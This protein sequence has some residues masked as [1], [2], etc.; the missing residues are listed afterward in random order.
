[1]ATKFAKQQ[2]RRR[3]AETGIVFP[4]S[5]SIEVER[6][7]QDEATPAAIKSIAQLIIK[8][9]GLRSTFKEVESLKVICSKT[10]AIPDSETGPCKADR[11]LLALLGELLFLENSRPVHRQLLS[12]L[13]RLPAK[14]FAAFRNIILEKVLIIA[15]DFNVRRLERSALA[16]S[17]LAQSEV[18]LPRAI[19]ADT[20]FS[21]LEYKP[22]SQ[23]LRRVCTEALAVLAAGVLDV[24]EAAENGM[25]IMQSSAEEVQD[26]VSGMYAILQRHGGYIAEEAGPKGHEAIAAAAEAMLLLLQSPHIV[27]R[28]A[29][30]SAAVLLGSACLLPAVPP[31]TLAA[32]IAVGLWQQD[33]AL[34]EQSSTHPGA[35]QS[36]QNGFPSSDGN[37][38]GVAE[39][40]LMAQ[41]R[42]LSVELSKLGP[43][44][45]VCALKG[46]LSMLPRSALCA[47]LARLTFTEASSI[48]T[49][50]GGSEAATQQTKTA[51]HKGTSGT[52]P[53]GRQ[54]HANDRQSGQL[55]QLDAGNCTE[56]QSGRS[57]ECANG[58]SREGTQCLLLDGALPFACTAIATAPDA[59]SKFHAV[60]LLTTCLQRVKDCLED[61]ARSHRAASSGHDRQQHLSARPRLAD[62]VGKRDEPDSD[63]DESTT[64]EQNQC[65]SS[66]VEPHSRAPEAVA[67]PLVVPVL[68]SKLRSRV[69]S[70][71]WANWEEPLQQTVKHIHAAFDALLDIQEVQQEEAAALGLSV[72]AGAATQAFL[73]ETACEIMNAGGHRKGKYIPLRA[74]TSR[75]GASQLL[76][77]Q[78]GLIRDTVGAMASDP[79]CPA[80]AGLLEAVLGS[81]RHECLA[82]SGSQEEAMAE[83]REAWVP[84]VL[85]ALTSVN[86]RLQ[87]NVSVYGLPVPLCMD[88]GSLVVL[89]QRILD[90]DFI[91]HDPSTS[92]DGQVAAL[93]AV[94]KVA[95]QLQLVRELDAVQV[96]GHAAVPIPEALLQRA[97][98][99]ANEGL[100]V[101]AMT[102]AC[103][104]PKTTAMPG[105][106][107]V[108][109]VARGLLLGMRC[110]STSLRNKWT[111]L[112][113]KL[114]RRVATSTHSVLH[115]WQVRPDAPA[116]ADPAERAHDLAGLQ[117]QAAFTRWLSRALLGSLYPG[118]PFERKFLAMLLLN[119]L[120]VVWDTPDKAVRCSSPGYGHREGC[121]AALLRL[122]DA[123]DV[124]LLCPGF[125]GAKTVQASCSI[126]ADVTIEQGTLSIVGL[127]L[128]LLG[129]VVDSWDKLRETATEALMA[130]PAPLPGL[131]Q[132]AQVADL[133][134]WARTLVSSPRVRESDA[135]AR[136][137]SLVFRKYVLRLMWRVQIKPDGSAA[138]QDRVNLSEAAAE[139][140]C[141]Q[142]AVAHLQSL[143][144]CLE[145]DVKESEE[146]FAAACRHSLAHGNLLSLRYLV[147]DIPWQISKASPARVRQMQ[148]WISR[149]LS[150]LLRAAETAQHPLSTP[151]ETMNISAMDVDGSDMN[152]ED[153]EDDSDGGDSNNDSQLAPRAQVI[154]TGCWLT[155]KEVALLL[156]CLARE[157]PL[158]R[159]DTPEMSFFDP[160]LL[161]SMGER[162]MHFMGVI[163]H[164]GAVEKAQAGF[165]ALTERLLRE[166]APALN[167]LPGQWLAALLERMR[168]PGQGRDD[169]VRRSAGLPFAFVAL[170]LAEPIGSHKTLLHTGMS[171]LLRTAND[172]SLSEPWPRVHAFNVLRLA[173]NDKNL[174]TDSS[175]FFAEGIAAA[176]GGM[177][178]SEWE[179][180]NSASLTFTSLVVRTVGFKNVLKGEAPKRAITG[181]EFFHRF[182]LLHSY[183]LEQL[184]AAAAALQSPSAALHPSLYPI[185]VLL[186]R[187]RP[188]PHSRNAAE[189]DALTPAAFAPVVRAFASARPLAVR[190][191]A[192]RALAPLVP[193]EELCA[194]LMELLQ[195]VPCH[196]PLVN[197]NQVH[198]RL[199]QARLLL[200][201]NAASTTACELAELIQQTAAALV[202][203]RQLMQADSRIPAVIRTE[204]LCT[205][206]ALVN[207]L[208]KPTPPYAAPM[209]EADSGDTA[210]SWADDAAEPG[211]Q[212]PP[213]VPPV[214]SSA[215]VAFAGAVQECCREAVAS[216][217]SSPGGAAGTDAADPMRSLFLKHAALLYF[218]PALC[219]LL[220]QQ[221]A[222]ETQ[223]AGDS[224]SCAASGGLAESDVAAAL[225]HPLY[226][227]RAATLKALLGRFSSGEAVPAWLLQL[228]KAH[229]T[230]ETHH[231]A[232]QRAL[233]LLTLP[234]APECPSEP[235]APS[236]HPPSDRQQLRCSTAAADKTGST[237]NHTSAGPGQAWAEVHALQQRLMDAQHPQVQERA[238]RGLGAAMRSPIAALTHSRASPTDMNARMANL[239]IA[240]DEGEAGC[241]A[242]LAGLRGALGGFLA[243]LRSF[244]AASQ[245]SEM[246]LAAIT[247]LHSSTLLTALPTPAAQP[248]PSP[249]LDEVEGAALETW[250]VAL[251]LMEDEDDEVREAAAAA[252][253]DAMGAVAGV[254]CAGLHVE[255][256]ERQAFQFLG[257]CCGHLPPFQ[258]QLMRWVYRPVGGGALDKE[259]QPGAVRKLFDKEIDNHHEEALLAAQLASWQLRSLIGR[260]KGDAL[261]D[262]KAALVAWLL[263]V[264]QDLE[265]TSGR[266]VEMHSQVSWPGGLTHH[267][268]AFA[269]LSRMLLALY[270][271]LALSDGATKE[272]HDW[273]SELQRSMQRCTQLLTKQP[274]QPLLG[275]TLLQVLTS[276]EAQGG[277]SLGSDAVRREL[278]DAMDPE[279]SVLFLLAPHVPSDVPKDID[280]I[281][282]LT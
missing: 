199:L 151:Q 178:A 278:G 24:L 210:R 158:S 27:A 20:M 95:R 233:Q 5:F 90:P 52:Y 237:G 15:D 10:V 241:A 273:L 209:D 19:L 103:I 7:A 6:L 168:A 44:S 54:Q 203:R 188:S 166:P 1:M 141:F 282:F 82:R 163:K 240:Q 51:A 257:R 174:S 186:A 32:R 99:H 167:G 67:D 202:A 108:R 229:M 13:Q 226:D 208:V 227:V 145:A 169:I 232:T 244:S 124:R 38:V 181:A 61:A 224:S 123:Q 223:S 192:A 113:G 93:V 89:L 132:A 225:A 264:M 146:D 28:E 97:I 59:H 193:P 9:I 130:L 157:A 126:F 107:E 162:L 263:Q 149:V 276:L 268:D 218:G 98:A 236:Q 254:Q 155:L 101:D 11:R 125:L 25:R 214:S 231:K 255:Q 41:G 114:L 160:V 222:A 115:R 243:V 45:R 213:S 271:A 279:F 29:L 258:Q 62:A 200:E 79:I 88:S 129:S 69:M 55:E 245:P 47:P 144:D 207:L 248:P 170:F 86:E 269:P 116:S 275:N 182:P 134:R 14:R 78:P 76:A 112:V 81:L 136:L 17:S 33:S 111:T 190:H 105:P 64:S 85:E 92:P 154:V 253:G 53:D 274:L 191:L 48:W 270:T 189:V 37:H 128:V 215:A 2:K 56:R 221:H 119:T 277:Q 175:G 49:P 256:I 102:L 242:L 87:N 216:G 72:Q 66:S 94:L 36:G 150:L 197:C 3:W 12:G 238:L 58:L 152:F 217:G 142:A 16:V 74:L 176:I 187:L 262:L 104:H 122:A 35:E 22:I 131:E 148:A 250:Y 50:A 96:P 117:Q 23:E 147:P 180:R 139:E 172:T 272:R 26:A 140:E 109:L 173:F 247:A 219:S 184:T 127:T 281:D 201:T 252:A 239:S 194:A 249:E 40:H 100:L 8:L 46:W 195:D 177:S 266:L 230:K 118:A 196:G 235:P 137:Q 220:K 138:V 80:A 153:L 57:G 73:E 110:V 251:H 267:Q 70:I 159:D 106:L 206:A 39:A 164:N 171:E 31:A 68:C 198:G 42:S 246:R 4:S 261:A 21:L 71:L 63:A 204:F 30:S 91:T 156:G 121:L 205:A 133:L 228:L 265:E 65:C 60:A 234:L 34:S 183:L 43:L 280:P 143:A 120:L 84:A 259:W 212:P 260:L 83:W 135:G 185:L 165:I 179:I 161:A 77:L 18:Q 75:M 211:R